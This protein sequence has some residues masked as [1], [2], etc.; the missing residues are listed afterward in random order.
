MERLEEVV[1]SYF[2]SYRLRSG[3]QGVPTITEIENLITE[4][5]SKTR[6]IYL[7]MVSDSLTNTDESDMIA[8]KKASTS[9]KE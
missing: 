8:S 7:R 9:R 3:D 2:E 4:L 1:D 5:K 6:D